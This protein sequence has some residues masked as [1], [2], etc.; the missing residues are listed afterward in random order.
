MKLLKDFK[1][2][3]ESQVGIDLIKVCRFFFTLPRFFYNLFII[4]KLHGVDV[5]LKPCVHDANDFAG[6]KLAEYF[7]QDLFV[8]QMIFDDKPKILADVGSRVDGFVAN[9]ASFREITVFDIRE[10]TDKINNV[11][12]LKQD[13]TQPFDNTQKFDMVTCLHALEHFGLGRYGDPIIKDAVHRGIEGLVNLVEDN[14]ILIISTPTGRERIEFNANWIFDAQKLCGIFDLLNMKLEAVF[15]FNPEDK[16]FE[17][18][19]PEN[20]TQL[21]DSDYNLTVFKLLKKESGNDTL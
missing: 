2:F 20:I 12:F 14:G 5:T 13:I 1:W 7:Y 4:K 10:L 15:K 3:L 21:S 6:S 16:N 19:N 17:F 11:T 8:A 18:L 9:V